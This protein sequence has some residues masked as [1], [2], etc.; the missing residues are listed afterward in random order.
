MQLEK[1]LKQLRKE[2]DAI[3][4]KKHITEE[5]IRKRNVLSIKMKNCRE[6]LMPTR[7][8]INTYAISYSYSP[9]NH[10]DISSQY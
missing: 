5:D 10:Q 4:A 1:E 6:R 7:S 8:R 2:M 3:A 9:S